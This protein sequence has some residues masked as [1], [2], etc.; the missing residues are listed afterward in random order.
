MYSFGTVFF[1]YRR[2]DLLDMLIESLASA[3][4]PLPFIIAAPGVD[5]IIVDHLRMTI[6]KTGALGIVVGFVSQMDVLSHGA[7]GWFLVIFNI[8]RIRNQSNSIA[9]ARRK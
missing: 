6:K 8:V 3:T 4:P 1:P 9:D 7:T 5:S 2:L